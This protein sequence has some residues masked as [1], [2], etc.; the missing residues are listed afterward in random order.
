M[1]ESYNHTWSYQNCIYL[2]SV[3]MSLS[4]RI[5]GISSRLRFISIK[6]FPRSKKFT[7]LRS[8]VAGVAKQTIEG[9]VRTSVNY[10]YAIEALQHRY[11]RTTI[12]ILSLVKWIVQLETEP[13]A[14]VASLRELHDTLKNRVRALDVWG[15]NPRIHSRILLPIFETKLPSELSEK[16]ELELTWRQGRKCWPWSIFQVPKQVLSK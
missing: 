12:V 9:F 11:G 16:R 14:G 3:E 8:V 10:H 15:E 5:F 13:N 2:S 7:Y 1:G 6:T 4:F